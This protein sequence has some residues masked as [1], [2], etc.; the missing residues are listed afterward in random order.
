MIGLRSEK[1]INQT[2]NMS[3]SKTIK[4]K[5]QGG[6]IPG[7]RLYT[8]KEAAIYLGRGEWGVRELIWKQAIPVVKEEGGRKIF[9]D[10][11]DLENYINKNKSFYR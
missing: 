2:L 3:K 7:K 6:F 10:I 11:I 4:Q 8:I 9:I 5:T 1:H